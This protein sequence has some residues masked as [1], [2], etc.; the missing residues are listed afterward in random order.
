M[1]VHHE[2]SG[3]F[4]EGQQILDFIGPKRFQQGSRRVPAS[5]IFNQDGNMFFVNIRFQEVLGVC[6]R[7]PRN[8]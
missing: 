3:R 8:P 2:D 7:M 4:R 5:P 1:C 6:E